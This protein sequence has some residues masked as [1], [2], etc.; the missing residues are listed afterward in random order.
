M[1]YRNEF[2]GGC[3]NGLIIEDYSARKVLCR[4]D[5]Y[6]GSCRRGG[7]NSKILINRRWDN[8]YRRNGYGAF[9]RRDRGEYGYNGYGYDGYGYDGYGYDGYG[10]DWNY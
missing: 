2:R 10:Y 3:G 9:R 6:L 8:L 1:C 7:W 5:R 4:G